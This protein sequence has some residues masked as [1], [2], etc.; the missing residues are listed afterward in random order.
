MPPDLF[1]L[2]LVEILP[3]P[4]EVNLQSSETAEVKLP[5]TLPGRPSKNA[6]STTLPSRNAEEQ[7]PFWLALCPIPTILTSQPKLEFGL[8][9]RAGSDGI[10]LE[11]ASPAGDHVLTAPNLKIV[12]D[13]EVAP[14]LWGK[15]PVHNSGAALNVP[16]PSVALDGWMRDLLPQSVVAPLDASDKPKPVG[17]PV[18]I[19][20]RSTL[21]T[22]ARVTIDEL[23]VAPPSGDGENA[24]SDKVVNVGP[25]HSD[26]QSADGDRKRESEPAPRLGRPTPPAADSVGT[27]TLSVFV[28][29][30]SSSSSPA[31]PGT[32]EPA[33]SATTSPANEPGSEAPIRSPRSLTV[34][35]QESLGRPVDVRF[36]ESKG[37]VRVTVRTED[38]QLAKAIA[39]EL[40]KFERGL[41]SRGWSSELHAPNQ[42]RDSKPQ[43]EPLVSARERV[44]PD[45]QLAR[46]ELT[47]HEQDPARQHRTNWDEEIEDRITAAALRRLSIAGGEM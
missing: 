8:A 11:L 46:A 9:V 19:E 37:S 28:A 39:T 2:L 14:G 17:V 42:L 16:R 24:D 30:R 26:E 4:E 35:I 1:H 21:E 29:P 27:N 36:V 44:Q 43:A 25:P 31:S 22:T 32:T 6:P 3:V 23:N 38:N 5:T 15:G 41:E 10:G 45:I 20:V 34:R 7:A 12:A 40:P 47:Q 13:E 33:Q 18:Q